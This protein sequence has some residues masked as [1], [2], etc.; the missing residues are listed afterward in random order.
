[1]LC[2]GFA[3]RCVSEIRNAISD[4]EEIE[5]GSH[6]NITQ[7]RNGKSC[8]VRMSELEEEWEL[9]LSEAQ[10]RARAAGK[11]DIAD[12]LNLRRRND[13]LRRTATEW[14]INVFVVMAGEAN[15]HGAGIQ[16]EQHE[17]NQFRRGNATMVGH[18]I[19]LRR[20]VRA[21][22]I[23]TGWPR[24]PKHGIVSGGGLACANIKHFGRSRSNAELLLSHAKN[25]GPCWLMTDRLGNS[26]ALTEENLRA[27]FR[28]LLS[29]D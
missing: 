3:I 27:Q 1:M 23:E 25:G 7:S 18:R 11:R 20:G 15:R 2:P 21:L 12:Y 8:F 29:D 4:R 17:E 22:T 13:L 26:L 5:L 10:E 9:A 19:T 6:D 14:F 16:I 28:K 24:T